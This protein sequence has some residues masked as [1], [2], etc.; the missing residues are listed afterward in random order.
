[1]KNGGPLSQIGRSVTVDVKNQD[2]S[3]PKPMLILD[4]F[5]AQETKRRLQLR[6]PILP[7]SYRPINVKNLSVAMKAT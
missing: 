6:F 2:F 1:M 7:V 5:F 3:E 4:D